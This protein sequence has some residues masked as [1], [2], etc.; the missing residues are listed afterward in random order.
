MPTF[1]WQQSAEL[2]N[3]GD[4]WGDAQWNALEARY[5]TGV[6]VA[7]AENWSL[8]VSG[9]RELAAQ[10]RDDFEWH[11]TL[12]LQFETFVQHLPFHLAPAQLTVFVSHQRR[13]AHWAEWAA[14]ASTEA[15]CDY[16]LDIHDPALTFATA[17]ALPPPIKSVLIA[18]IIEMALL[19]STHIVS[20]QTHN[21]QASRWIPYEFGRAKERRSLATNAAS[22]FQAGVTPTGTTDYLWLGFCAFTSGA[23]SSWLNTAGHAPPPRPNHRWQRPLPG[24]L[25]N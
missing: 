22:W 9:V 1:D 5:R 12:R 19:N 10:P 2:F 8:L 14:W 25:P 11:R 20:M 7:G 15:H 3:E 21:A 16:W 6:D 4:E 24:P 18:G 13:D 23:L 17:V